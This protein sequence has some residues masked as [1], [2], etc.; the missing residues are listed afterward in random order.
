LREGYHESNAMFE[1]VNFSCPF[2]V[3]HKRQNQEVI[4]N[5]SS[6]TSLHL[7]GRRSPSYHQHQERHLEKPSRH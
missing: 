6:P 1:Y 2:T 5:G 4:Y 3:A 7:A